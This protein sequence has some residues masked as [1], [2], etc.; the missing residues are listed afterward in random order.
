MVPCQAGAVGMLI[1]VFRI[2]SLVRFAANPVRHY[3]SVPPPPLLLVLNFPVAIVLNPPLEGVGTETPDRGA[4]ERRH[5]QPSLVLPLLLLALAAAAAV[6]VVAI[7]SRRH[8]CL[9][10]VPCGQATNNGAED[11]N[12]DARV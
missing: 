5:Q 1:V 2:Q 9:G 10:D 7:I 4:D 8:R 3:P 11:S 6:M 12:A